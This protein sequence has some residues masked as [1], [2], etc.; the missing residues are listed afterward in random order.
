M[1]EEDLG[2]LP[3]VNPREGIL[4]MASVEIGR[5]TSEVFRRYELTA[6]EQF[7]CLSNEIRVIAQSCV[8]REHR[9]LAKKESERETF[10]VTPKRVE[11]KTF[12]VDL[13]T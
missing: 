12:T 11:P 13:K 9:E 2:P 8:S 1:N 3:P 7:L 10:I 6:S 5:V 4:M